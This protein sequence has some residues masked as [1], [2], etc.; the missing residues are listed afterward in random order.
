MRISEDDVGGGEQTNL[1]EVYAEARAAGVLELTKRVEDLAAGTPAR[2]PGMRTRIEAG[3]M[4]RQL[5]DLLRALEELCK[6]IGVPA[7]GDAGRGRE[8][9]EPRP[10]REIEERRERLAEL[11]RRDLDRDMER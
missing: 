7:R 4:A 2:Y 1:R 6:R 8:P 3:A 5:R 10:E 11:R 9:E